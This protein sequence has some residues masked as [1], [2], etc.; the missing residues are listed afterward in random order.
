VIGLQ[1]LIRGQMV[2]L[3]FEDHLREYR[4]SVHWATMVP[5]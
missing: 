2:R 4:S 5:I 3:L 1:S